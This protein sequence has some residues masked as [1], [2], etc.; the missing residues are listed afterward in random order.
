MNP[1]SQVS[2]PLDILLRGCDSVYTEEE[3]RRRL[4]SGKVM[5][6][7]L[8]MDPT[9]PD[10]TL[11]HTVVLR[12]LRQFQDLG[13]KAVL[14]IGDYTARIG[15]PT[16]RSKARPIL[17]PDEITANADTYLEQAGK[18]LDLSDDKLEVRR[19]SEWLSPMTFADVIKLIILIPV[20]PIL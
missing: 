17:T 20:A 9:A 11:G 13:H 10:L 5:R 14:I 4:A 1:A 19:N 7:K 8:G 2:E 6:V 18:V 16:G 3:L 15:D 12:K